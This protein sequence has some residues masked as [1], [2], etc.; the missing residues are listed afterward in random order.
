MNEKL[1]CVQELEDRIEKMSNKIAW[2]ELETPTGDRITVSVFD[3]ETIETEL[4]DTLVEGVETVQENTWIGL[5]SGRII[6]VAESREQV[7]EKIEQCL[8]K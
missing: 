8:S 1:D 7:K 5:R 4:E 3:I 2:I 6:A